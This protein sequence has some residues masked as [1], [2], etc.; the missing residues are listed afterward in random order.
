MKM[1]LFDTTF[2][3][4]LQE[5]GVDAKVLDQALLAIRAIDAMGVAYHEVGFAAS[6]HAARERI[7]ETMKLPLQGKVAA[8]GRTHDLDVDA[9]LQLKVP[10]GVLVGK[11]RR[12][13][14]EKVIRKGAEINEGMIHDSVARLVHNGVEV[15]YDA[16]H[17]FQAFFEVDAD[18]ALR[19]LRSAA[20]AGAHRIV[21][22]DTNGKMTPCQIERAIREVAKTVPMHMLGIHC[23]NDR[24]RAVANTEAAWALGV[25]HIQGTF[26]GFG[27]RVGNADLVTLI[28]NLV[29]DHEAT[30]VSAD[31]LRKL[32]ET[33]LL[34]CAVL[35][36]S[37]NPKHP[38]VGTKAFYTETGMHQ[39]G[40][41]RDYGNYWHIDPAL[42]GNMA[43]VGVTNQSGRANII[44]KAREIG[45]SIPEE[46]IRRVTDSFMELISQGY[47]FNLADA[48][49][50]LTLLR[51][52]GGFSEPFEFREYEVTSRSI[53]GH[54]TST[55][56]QLRLVLD[57]EPQLHSADGDGPV[58]AIDN[59]LRRTLRRKYPELMSV[60]LTD[61]RV[62]IF[63]IQRGSA[64]KVQVYTQFSDGK[65]FWNTVGA[66]DNIIEASWQAIVDGYR[67]KIWKNGRS[68]S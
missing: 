67:Y 10:V 27:E 66:H 17:F 1:E 24:G 34:V 29:F 3:D 64:A 19:T 49:F 32:T 23:H 63:N 39:S 26:G 2:R 65:S 13:D 11:S 51:L 47:D 5:E 20:C 21:L 68:S 44:A 61:Y 30:G 40:L 58:N 60:N 43:R 57:E 42:V 28:P 4:G 12:N 9:I 37:P 33:H 38:Y 25:R 7:R 31:Q 48:S 55:V 59:V 35:N 6:N 36:Q 41:D 18:Y 45:I 8:F 52:L 50:A 62:G 22:C 46:H 15:I 56:A 54:G 16:E 53:A 14:A